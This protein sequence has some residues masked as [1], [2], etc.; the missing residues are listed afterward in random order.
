MKIVYLLLILLC[1]PPA[2]ADDLPDLG[3]SA[4]AVLTP[5]DEQR[6]A[7]AIMREVSSSGEILNDIEVVDYLQAL[8]YRLVSQSSD[9]RQR[10]I[11]FV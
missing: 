4:Q 11:F 5:L 2:V 10:F 8:G 6:I 1:V 3:E 7:E 9:N